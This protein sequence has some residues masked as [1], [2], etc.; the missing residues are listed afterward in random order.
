M[1]GRKSGKEQL[2]SQNPPRRATSAPAESSG[3]SSLQVDRD[4]SMTKK[5]EE[6]RLQSA[7]HMSADCC[8]SPGRAMRPRSGELK[9]MIIR[10]AAQ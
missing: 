9:I 3:G 1:R 4:A 8:R 5:K 2:I 7:A 6:D 10:Y